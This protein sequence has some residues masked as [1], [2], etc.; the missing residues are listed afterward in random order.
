[1]D[2][3]SIYRHRMGTP[4]DQKTAIAFENDE[5]AANLVAVENTV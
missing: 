5:C 3:G 1:M 2:L 4:L